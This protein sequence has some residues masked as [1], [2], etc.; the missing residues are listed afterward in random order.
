MLKSDCIFSV[1]QS[2]QKW[3]FFKNRNGVLAI[4]GRDNS[5]PSSS[6]RHI[7]FNHFFLLFSD[8]V[9][10]FFSIYFFDLLRTIFFDF[11]SIYCARKQT[12]PTHEKIFQLNEQYTRKMF[13]GLHRAQHKNSCDHGSLSC[14]KCTNF[15][16][17]E[18]RLEISSRQESVPERCEA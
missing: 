17:K 4:Y 8:S 2:I 5:W 3:R 7:S 18:K 14:P 15:S 10:I 12:M 11:F 1:L 13:V 6:K 16:T 9:A